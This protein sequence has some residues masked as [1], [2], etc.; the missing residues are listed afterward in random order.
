MSSSLGSLR[1]KLCLSSR[2]QARCGRLSSA[3]RHRAS[4][5]ALARSEQPLD[6]ER[7]ADRDRSDPITRQAWPE[8]IFTD[9]P[10]TDGL[11]PVQTRPSGHRQYVSIVGA[12]RAV[13]L[14]VYTSRAA[15][16]LSTSPLS[17][18]AMAESFRMPT[19]V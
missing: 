7:G 12:G 13:A 17:V 5:S 11:L 6:A 19:A 10:G 15:E 18:T 2:A 4:T 16:L 3:Q 14:T 1:A 8:S 9:A